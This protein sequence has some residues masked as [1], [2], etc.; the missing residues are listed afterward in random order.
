MASQIIRCMNGLSSTTS[1][2]GNRS[3][4]SCDTAHHTDRDRTVRRIHPDGPALL[5][6]NGLSNDLDRSLVQAAPARLDVPLTDV[7][8]ACRQKI[9]KHARATYQTTS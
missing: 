1:T 6:T 9:D 5:A 2:V 4:L 8:R 7:H 3:E